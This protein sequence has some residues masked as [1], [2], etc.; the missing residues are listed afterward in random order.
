MTYPVLIDSISCGRAKPSPNPLLPRDV[1]QTNLLGK[2]LLPARN[3]DA[4]LDG[5]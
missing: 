5:P 4:S 3:V 2:G 1:V